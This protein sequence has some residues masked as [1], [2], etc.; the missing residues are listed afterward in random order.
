MRITTEQPQTLIIDRDP[1]RLCCSQQHW[2]SV[3]P[4]GRV[5]C[6]ICYGRYDPDELH[7][8]A[9]GVTWDMC[10]GCGKEVGE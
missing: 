10:A 9:T 4:D 5:M 6:C 8:D 3:C 7:V 1:V 2:G